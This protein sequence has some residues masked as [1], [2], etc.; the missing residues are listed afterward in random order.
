[1]ANR[2]D[3]T[4]DNDTNIVNESLNH[5]NTCYETFSKKIAEQEDLTTEKL[6]KVIEESWQEMNTEFKKD[7]KLN[8]TLYKLIIQN[9]KAV[10][11]RGPLGF[12]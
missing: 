7:Y 8:E 4:C 11:K 3:L 5:L 6:M 9:F 10:C 1:M 2:F 12:F